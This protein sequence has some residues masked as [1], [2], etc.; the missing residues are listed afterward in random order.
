M[1]L[2]AAAAVAGV[3]GTWSPCGFS[4]I[5]T[6]AGTG[7]RLT[8]IVSA[9]TFT[10]GALVGGS[11]TFGGLALVGL[12]LHGAGG[13]LATALA[14]VI[15]VATA[16]AEARGVRIVPQIRRQ[17]PEPWRRRL[18][19][20]LASALYGLL[21]GLGFTTFVLTFGVWALAAISFALA[22]VELGVVVGLCFA[23]G[24]ALPVAVV[25]PVARQ[26]AGMRMLELMAER[27][28][29]LHGFRLAE[30]VAL[31]G[32]AVALTGAEATASPL[33][34]G[35]TARAARPAPFA[36]SDPSVAGGLLVWERQRRGVLRSENVSAH[37]RDDAHHIGTLTSALP[38]SDPAVGGSLLAWRAG[39]RVHVVRTADFSPVVDLLIPDVDALAVSDAWLAYRTHGRA[40]DRIGARRLDDPGREATVASSNGAFGLGRPALSGDVLV[41]HVAGRRSSRIVAVNLRTSARTVVRRSRLDQLTNPSLLG[42]SLLYVRQSNAAQLLQVGALGREGRDRVL[43]RLAPPAARDSGYEA[44]HSRVTRTP[45]GGPAARMTLWTTALSPRYAYVTLLP[46]RQRGRPTIARVAR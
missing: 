41:F 34:A 27:P 29:I 1:L 20:P 43:Y 13:G 16:L 28:R 35:Q 39:A 15:A 23:A 10:A 19:L 26:P 40:G 14:A 4:M 45:P 46:T 11:V 21:L 38:G 18:P 25:A 9:A 7:R 36:G 33:M 32:F 22:D 37:S 12:A 24:R 6:I 31:G 17:V 8:T 44:R 5:E 3:A 2:A 42:R 30:A